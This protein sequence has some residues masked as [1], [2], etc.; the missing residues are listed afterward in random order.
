MCYKVSAI[1]I[2][3]HNIHTHIPFNIIIKK[4]HLPILYNFK[5]SLKL[6]K[7]HELS[8]KPDILQNLPIKVLKKFLIEFYRQTDTGNFIIKR[9]KL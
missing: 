4:S 7:L 3:A 2:L 6:L 8:V 9:T 1:I 5:A